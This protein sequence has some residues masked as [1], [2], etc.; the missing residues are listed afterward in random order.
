[1][2]NIKLTLEYDGSRYNGFIQPPKKGNKTTVSGKITDVLSRMESADAAASQQVALPVLFCGEKTAAGVHA[3][4]QIVNFKTDS[5]LSVREIRTYLNHYLP[6][7]IVVSEAVETADRFHAEL[8][9]CSRTYEYH[10]TCSAFPDVFSRKY[11][12]F[13]PQPLDIDAMEHAAGLLTGKHDFAAFSSGKTKKSTARELYSIDFET[14]DISTDNEPDREEIRIYL[15]ANGFLQKMPLSLIGTLLDIGFGKRTPDCIEQIFSGQE[16]PSH[17][18]T[19]H[20]LFL[21]EIEYND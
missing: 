1:M 17:S 15:K 18:A 19:A 14:T 5:V 13:L 6:Q 21:K 20:A 4:K 3:R 8:N 7:D 2:R 12:H 10:I 9:A 16:A 11:T